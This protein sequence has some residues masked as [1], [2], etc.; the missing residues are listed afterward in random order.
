MFIANRGPRQSLRLCGLGNMTRHKY[1]FVVLLLLLTWTTTYAQSANYGFVSPNTRDDLKL[2][3]AINRMNSDDE[4]RL[5][6]KARNLGCVVKTEIR[7]F[8]ALGS[9]SDGAEHSVML[10][11]KSDE[12]SLRYVLSRLGRDAKQKSILYFHPEPNGT[13][14]I[15]RLEPRAG[16]R[17]LRSLANA[18][19]KAGIKFRTLVPTGKNTWIYLVDLNNE[20]R[21]NVKTAAR[22][23]RAR[24]SV[25]KGNASFVGA[26]QVSESTTVF[27]QHIN[28]YETKHPNLPPT[29]DVKS[30]R[31]QK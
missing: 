2:D 8:R 6:A 18:L 26:D 19:D 12:D 17:N 29:C 20:L 16:N 13:S 14:L 23:L 1:I 10:R 30:R 21:D 9:W 31:Q 5:V 24:V 11:M 4:K 3:E 25:E 22:R 7:V 27:S 28:D 15:Y